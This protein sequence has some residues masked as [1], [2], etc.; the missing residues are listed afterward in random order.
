MGL[1]ELQK[2]TDC[3][4][5]H[6][7]TADGVKIEAANG[8]VLRLTPDH[9]VFTTRGLV[10]AG[11]IV[12]GDEIFTCVHDKSQTTVTAISL[13]SNQEYFGLNCVHSIVKANG[14]K[15]ST[16]G[17]FHTLPATWMKYASSLLGAHRASRVADAVASLVFKLRLL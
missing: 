15:T 8:K 16:F 1:K 3:R 17:H 13:E 4:I 2:S 7:L 11:E 5:P 6:M 10:S 14:F 12:V 9:L